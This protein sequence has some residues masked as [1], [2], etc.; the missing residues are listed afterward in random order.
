M[1]NLYFKVKGNND[2]YDMKDIYT[3]TTNITY[4]IKLVIDFDINDMSV[5][6]NDEFITNKNIFNMKR[7]LVNGIVTL[8]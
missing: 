8:G 7:S 2:I 6:V 5:F 1:R 3:F 4:N